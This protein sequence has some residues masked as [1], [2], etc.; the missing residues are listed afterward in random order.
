[1][2]IRWTRA[3]V[4][5]RPWRSGSSPISVRISRTA[6]STRPFGP[7]L[8]VPS[9]SMIDAGRLG[10]LADLVLDLVDDAPDVA[11]QVGWAGHGRYSGAGRDGTSDARAA[12]TIRPGRRRDEVVVP[13]QPRG[14]RAPRPPGLAERDHLDRIRPVAEA[15]DLADRLR[16][17]RCRRPATRRAGRG[18]SAGRSSRSTARCPGSPG[19]RAWTASSSSAA[20]PSRSSAPRL[21]RGRQRAAVARLLA[22][23]ADRQQLGV[24]QLEEARRASAGRPRPEPV[25]GRPAPR[26]ARPAARG[27]CGAASRSPGSRSHS[28][29][30]P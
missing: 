8:P 10:L 16:R 15:L 9:P 26:R 19:A 4:P 20:S 23:E 2:Y 18:P 5:A 12:G 7:W 28:G 13:E 30:G 29:G 22:A 11:R 21:D 3:G 17:A 1:M 14:D 6:A 25:E 24:G 27:R